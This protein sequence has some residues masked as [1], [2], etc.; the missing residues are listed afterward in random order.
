MYLFLWEKKC[1][2]YKKV[3]S[4]SLHKTLVFFFFFFLFSKDSVFIEYDA[5]ITRQ[6]TSWMKKHASFHSY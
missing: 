2:G 3:K 6:T 1:V 4:H 5:S